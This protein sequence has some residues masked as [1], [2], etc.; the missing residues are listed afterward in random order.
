MAPAPRGWTAG[1]PRRVARGAWARPASSA[2]AAARAT[3]AP[4]QPDQLGGR[5]ARPLL[6]V[7]EEVRNREHQGPRQAVVAVDGPPEVLPAA[8]EVARSS[9]ASK[10]EGSMTC[11][12]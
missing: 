7:D 3:L 11:S 2:A 8:V 1:R 4:H 5:A 9:S 6:R 10:C 12:S